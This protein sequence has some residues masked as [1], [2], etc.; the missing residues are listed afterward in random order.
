[1]I[2]LSTV[3]IPLV[4][5]LLLIF[6][7]AIILILICNKLKLPS[8][9]GFLLTGVICGSNGIDFHSFAQYLPDDLSTIFLSYFPQHI[10][11]PEE[12][13]EILA[14]IGVVLLLFTIGLEFSIASLLRIKKAVF[15]GGSLQVVLTTGVFALC[16]Y[17]SS[18]DSWPIAIFMGMLFALSSTAIV[19]KILAEKGEINQPYG[20]VV[21]AILIFQDIAL[22]PLMLLVPILASGD[23]STLGTELLI[24]AMKALGTLA[25]MVALGKYV[26]PSVLYRIAKA[27]SNDLFIISI[28][29][30]CFAIA[31]ITSLAG[32][33]LALGAFMAGLVISETQY[34][35]HAIDSIISFKEL[36]TSIFFISVGLLMDLNFVIANFWEILFYT[37][38]VII[39][40]VIIIAIV[41]IILKGRL[42]TVIAVSLG[43]CQVGEFSFVL[44]KMG[45]KYGLMPI[46][47]YQYFLCVAVMT[48]IITP[49]LMNSSNVISTFLLHSKLIPN[50]IKARLAGVP[51]NHVS[52]NVE[53]TKFKN[54]LIIIGYNLTSETITH[55]ASEMGIPFVVVEEDVQ[56][57]REQSKNKLPIVFGV[58]SSNELLKYIN[59]NECSGVIITESDLERAISVIDTIKKMN[60]DTYILAR[61]H[62]VKEAYKLKELGATEVL[63]DEIEMNVSMLVQII[64]QLDLPVHEAYKFA[65]YIKNLQ[66]ITDLQ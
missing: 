33:S 3:N 11:P 66:G 63:S 32:L 39:L 20:Q 13:V 30:I 16:I 49:I 51:I 52:Y 38:L 31:Y 57:V 55:G 59:I 41:V 28:M 37:A 34:G 54:H 50:N 56:V 8:I 27:K 25:V 44:S 6:S 18:Y 48:M 7:L 35:H 42:K 53:P 19:L 2:F 43:I 14:E 47:L 26:I 60:P 61:T 22:V 65:S 21:L 5:D 40:K 15:L 46:E 10:A 9:I 45:E 58:A 23:F 1:M 36:F 64:D 4:T 29:V 24:M 62:T 12:N 17:F